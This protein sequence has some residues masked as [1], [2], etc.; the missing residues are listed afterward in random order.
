MSESNNNSALVS[1]KRPTRMN[2]LQTPKEISD[3]LQVSESTILRMDYS[4]DLPYIPLRRGKRKK[5]IRFDPTTV[6]KWLD[7]RAKEAKQ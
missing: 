3:L 7:K 4:G 6:E 5:V 1:D 2:R